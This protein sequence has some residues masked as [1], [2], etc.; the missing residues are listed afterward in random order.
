MGKLRLR[1]TPVVE[2]EGTQYIFFPNHYQAE[3]R[4]DEVEKVQAHV[5]ERSRGFGVGSPIGME[6][7]LVLVL[8]L[9]A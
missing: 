6:N 8:V 2:L 4:R 5:Q 9:E 3:R 7:G 1:L